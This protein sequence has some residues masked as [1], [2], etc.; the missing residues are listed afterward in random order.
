MGQHCC[1]NNLQINAPEGTPQTSSQEIEARQGPDPTP[2][3][4]PSTIKKKK[5]VMFKSIPPTEQQ[6]EKTKRNSV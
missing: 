1:K 4:S 5:S 3:K 2:P 6:E